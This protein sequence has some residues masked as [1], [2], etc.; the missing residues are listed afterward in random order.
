MDYFLKSVAAHLYTHYNQSF[1]NI[2]LVLPNRRSG[3][4]L[5]NELMQFVD[6]KPIW[7][8]SVVTI[9]E[10]I[11]V[12]SEINMAEPIQLLA[13]LYAEYKKISGSIESFDN[14][15]A[16]GEVLLA[17]F[18]DVDKYLVN[19]ESVFVNVKNFKSI[20]NQIDFLTD[21]QIKV[22]QRFFTA[23]DAENPTTIKDE[24][25]KIWEILFPLYTRF[26]QNLVSKKLGTEGMVYQKALQTIKQ[27]KTEDFGFE[28]LFFIGF[29][30]IT[31]VEEEVFSVFKNLGLAYFFWDYDNLYIENKDMEAG[32][33]QRKYIKKFPPVMLNKN[34][35]QLIGKKIKLI[36]VPTNHGQIFSCSQILQTIPS[37]YATDT[38]IILSDEQLL[39]P[40]LNSIPDA[41]DNINITMGFPVID[42]LSGNF[43][44]GLL[45]L[46]Q[47]IRIVENQGVSYYYKQVATLLRHPFVQQICPTEASQIIDKITDENLYYL[48]SSELHQHNLL[49]ILFKDDAV[50]VGFAKYLEAVL[51]YLHEQISLIVDA[52]HSFLLESEFLFKLLMEFK[53][54]HV[55][56]DEFSLK[57]QL[58]TYFKLVRNVMQSMR[59]P[60]EGEP[61]SG[62]QIMGFLETRNLDFKNVIILS[63][64]EGVIPVQ[65]R[66][67]SFI[68]YSLRRGFG[69]PTGELNDAMYAYYFYRILQR[70]ENVWLLY[71]SGVSGMSTGERSRLVYQLEYDSNF[72][73]ETRVVA[74]SIDVASNRNIV[75]EKKEKVWE[76]LFEFLQTE[77]PR[78]LSPSALSIYLQCPLRFYFKSVAKVRETD[79]IDEVVDARLFGNIFHKA[80]E[81]IYV[82]FF[83]DNIL[84]TS[85]LLSQLLKNDKKIDEIINRAFAMAFF[86]ESTSRKFPIEGKNQII[87]DVIKKYLI[88]LL[89]KDKEYAPFSI[90]GLESNASIDYNIDAN[91]DIYRI[92]LGGQIDRL[93]RSDKGLRVVDYKT[94]SDKLM[95]GDLSDVFNADKIKDTKAIFQTFIYSYIISHKF[96]SES[97]ILPM[98]YQVKQ[99][100]DERNSF[101]IASKHYEP[102]QSGNFLDIKTEVEGH[103]KVVLEELFN[104][105]IPFTQTANLLICENCPYKNM[106][107]R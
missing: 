10:F 97:V 76:G 74:Q 15:Y 80:A 30:A 78:L 68:P 37:E 92:N 23:F 70:A 62:L 83:T 42:S 88:Q 25:L 41:F 64:N 90:V 3:V 50:A 5:L 105:T 9:N 17:D 40:L 11:Q 27:I 12:Y 8:P 66:S 34:N 91:N 79:D 21:E 87:F 53:K 4:F 99:L 6:D 31:P 54:L 72:E 20:E 44:D 45:Q 98:V 81:E 73:V 59:V 102:F 85:D 89:E 22:L 86:G 24:F 77:N 36:S 82:D 33:F 61:I 107:G 69:L 2:K 16:W 96:E 14:F 84:V 93:D 58:P 38:A 18:N 43:V 56:L 101:E 7:S 13:E 75:I 47:N 103:L 51:E 26:K 48:P 39:M 46:Y 57:L 104:K 28:Q 94:G 100:F 67:S 49:S 71:N 55:Q 29:N 32:L 63:V 106:C 52:T 95:F 60:F 35:N 1:S 65:G 19:A